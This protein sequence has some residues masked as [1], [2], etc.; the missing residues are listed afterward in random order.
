MV[1]PV[2]TVSNGKKPDIRS[3]VNQGLSTHRKLR[4]T[5]SKL[6][7]PEL[8]RLSGSQSLTN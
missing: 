7:S 1:G 6:G 2:I 8:G 4:G 5:V 3:C